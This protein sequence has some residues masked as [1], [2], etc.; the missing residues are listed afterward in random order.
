M[1]F[2]G[3]SEALPCRAPGPTALGR[4][5]RVERTERLSLRSLSEKELVGDEPLDIEAQIMHSSKGW[6]SKSLTPTRVTLQVDLV[7]DKKVFCTL[8]SSKAIF[9]AAPELGSLPCLSL[10]QPSK[11]G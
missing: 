9:D 1:G 3:L 11:E 10:P 2:C 7:L 4:G 6:S 5:S 8:R